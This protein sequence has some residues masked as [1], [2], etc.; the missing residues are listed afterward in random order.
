MIKCLQKGGIFT[1]KNEFK[2]GVYARSSG[3]S[4][5]ISTHHGHRRVSC[6]RRKKFFSGTGDI[7]VASFTSVPHVY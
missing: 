3:M 7:F 5:P 4:K 2:E 6:Q 1:G